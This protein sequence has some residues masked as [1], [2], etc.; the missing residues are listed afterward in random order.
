M[1]EILYELIL[2][3]LDE[4]K[5][6]KFSDLDFGQLMVEVPPIGYPAILLSIDYPTTNNIS[7]LIQEVRATI[8]LTI[9]TKAITETNSLASK[10]IRSQG[11]EFLRLRQKVYKKL[12]GFGNEE[13]YPF[14][15][16]SMRNE[17]LRQGLKTTVLQFET[18][19]HD[20]S[21]NS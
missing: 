16:K 14:E 19:F 18:S 4:I 12:Q 10:E 7:R 3:K 13:F 11:L 2:E 17:M 15:R 8:K 21:S 9:V 20:D 6:I 5:E 1:E